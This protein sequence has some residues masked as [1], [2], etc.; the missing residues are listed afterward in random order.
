MSARNLSSR[1]QTLEAQGTA[2][3]DPI[4]IEIVIVGAKDGRPD[5][6]RTDWHA[7]ADE[8]IVNRMRH[9]V[10]AEETAH[11]AVERIVAAMRPQPHGAVAMVPR[12]T[13]A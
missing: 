10:H 11:Q 8:V 12:D 6:T 9:K 1:L 7:H 4:I 3:R 5:G 13:P 2:A